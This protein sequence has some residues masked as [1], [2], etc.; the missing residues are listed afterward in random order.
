MLVLTADSE[1]KLIGWVVPND[2]DKFPENTFR[3]LNFSTQSVKVKVQD[4][5]KDLSRTSIGDFSI[6]ID[7][8][9]AMVGFTV[10][11]YANGN[12]YLVA[13]RRIGMAQGG[14][15]L[16]VLF[17]RSTEP[18]ALTVTN[19]TIDSGPFLRNYSDREI[20]RGDTVYH[21]SYIPAAQR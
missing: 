8:P 18:E 11:A 21:D 16:I 20:T 3:V 2:K 13:R 5:A 7:K 6:Q 4:L 15:R 17:P 10:A 19:L 14:R 12:R 1:D 9:R